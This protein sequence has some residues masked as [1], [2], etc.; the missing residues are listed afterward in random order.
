MNIDEVGG[1]EVLRRIL[2]GAE[3]SKAEFAGKYYRRA[4]KAKKII[5]KDFEE[6]FKK[7]DLIIMPVVPKFP[8]QIGQELELEDYYNYD[9]LT[10][11]ANLAEIP[12]ISVPGLE[13]DDIPVGV[14]ILAKKGNDEFLLK[15]SKE[16][17]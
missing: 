12:A 4:L 5:E 11:L 6:A 9:A 16:F 15:V 17:E 10:V 8:H 3:I 13:L 7:Y 1:R 2:G 14:Q